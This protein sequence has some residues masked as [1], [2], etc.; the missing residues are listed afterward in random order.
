MNKAKIKLKSNRKVSKTS[1]NM[2]NVVRKGS[3]I[4]KIWLALC[5]MGCVKF[6]RYLLWINVL[7]PSFSYSFFF[8]H[9]WCAEPDMIMVSAPFGST[10]LSLFFSG[11]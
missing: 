9:S 2:H 3:N 1:N 10:K 4:A 7:L 11:K 6:G 8:F 5:L